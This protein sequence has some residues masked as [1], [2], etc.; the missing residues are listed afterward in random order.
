VRHLYNLTALLLVVA[1]CNETLGLDAGKPGGVE[2]GGGAAG[3]NGGFAMVPNTGGTTGGGQGGMPGGSDTGG[4][5]GSGGDTEGG[6]HVG[7]NGAQAGRSAGAGGSDAGAG[8]ADGGEAGGG[9]ESGCSTTKDCKDQ[10]FECP[11]Y[12]CVRGACVNITSPECSTLLGAEW[13]ESSPEDEPYL[14]GAYARFNLEARDRFYLY[15]VLKFA[16]QEF[17]DYGP[18]PIDGAKRRPVMI[19]CNSELGTDMT[20]MFRGLTHMIDGLGISA[21]LMLPQRQEE[22]AAAAQYAYVSNQKDVFMLD[23]AGA[24]GSML[25]LA[26]GG[27]LWH[28]LGDTYLMALPFVPLVERV[29]ELVNPGASS[30]RAQRPTKL[31]LVNN[32][33]DDGYHHQVGELLNYLLRINGAP[34]DPG[35]GTFRDIPVGVVATLDEQIAEFEPDIV[36]D[37]FGMDTL[38]PDVDSAMRAKG[39]APPFY[40]LSSTRWGSYELANAIRAD[41]SLGARI[42]GVTYPAAEDPT[43][44]NAYLERSYYF[45]PVD[46]R[47]TENFYD[48]VYFLIYAAVAGG[49]G[50]TNLSE[51]MKRL[52]ANTPRRDIGPGEAMRSVL[53][54]LAIP[55]A[56]LSLYGTMGKPDFHLP[57]GGRISY[58][59]IWC[60]TERYG[61]IDYAL[62]VA[63]YDPVTQ[64]LDETFRDCLF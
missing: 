23:Y 47:W 60:I 29:E 8:G 5:S 44:Y 52:V 24:N 55:D 15:W 22:M 57:T 39:A 28:M 37:Y 46:L 40:V 36:V 54:R 35:L 59:S 26:D 64:R 16:M 4:R 38:E 42:V 32:P 2:A 61:Q 56:R 27:R 12:L 48:A 6:S 20:P 7:G 19:L 13:V 18:I 49:S 50:G 17:T 63:R 30:G 51:G 53:D 9:G 45:S 33:Y 1:A 25:T 43:L 58:G 14:V 31:A 21:I 34:V 41:P 10:G 11:P 3:A 62:D